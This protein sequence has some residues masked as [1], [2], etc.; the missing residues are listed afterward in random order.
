MRSRIAGRRVTLLPVTFAVA[1]VLPAVALG[2]LGWRL[3]EQDERLERQRVQDR[4]E[5]AAG[6]VTAD[7]EHELAD[8]ERGLGSSAPA[9]PAASVG[10]TVRLDQQGQVTPVAGARLAYDPSP[11]PRP[12]EPP[13]TAWAEAERLEFGARDA[14]GAA[15]A[16]ERLAASPDPQVRAGALVRGARVLRRSGR[17]DDALELYSALARTSGLTV[18]GDP[19]DL[20][21]RWARVELLAAHGRAR[22]ARAEAVGLDLDLR[23]GRW[24]LDRTTALT[25]LGALRPWRG[26]EDEA[27]TTSRVALT[28]GVA[29]VW[30]DWRAGA[31]AHAL[32]SG[33]RSLRV[34]GREVLVVW[35]EVGDDLVVYAAEPASLFEA[36]RR[37]RP[38]PGLAVALLDS[39]GRL[40]AGETPPPGGG[41]A[42]TRPGSDTRLPWTVRVA[43]A[44]TPSE[45]AA[46]GAARR[47]VIVAGLALLAFLVPATGYL[48]ARAVQRELALARQQATFVAAVSHEFR[49]PLT[50]LSHLLSLLRSDFQPS[51]ERRRQY[52]EV[53]ARETDRLRRFV[54]TLLDF[55]RIQAGEARYS[56]RPIDAAPVVGAVVEDFRGHAACGSHPVSLAADAAV[57][58]LSADPEALGRA[59]WNLLENAA[60]YSPDQTSITVRIEEEDGRVA[61]RVSDRGV[62]VP[63][64]EQPFVFDPFFRGAAAADS[65]VKGTGVGLAL[66]RHVAEAHGG[67]VRLESAPGEGSTFSILLPA[68]AGPA[69][70]AARRVS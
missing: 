11:P 51:P 53:M 41:P 9:T 20:M 49:S 69:P 26:D 55:G 66:V 18:I 34:G 58:P 62:G 61:I 60:K 56:P 52:Y 31:S 44:S 57:P 8:V 65:A 36:G 32:G 43:A 35:R 7:L 38:T 47:R 40:L 50:S 24:R 3:I 25:Y 37:S 48:V 46:A 14:R 19:A 42:V 5:S 23:E 6:G 27:R 16:Y 30:S 4:V 29:T 28:G 70:A 64:A 59:L 15:R 17:I 54:E 45:L 21:A 22:E 10:L 33:R 63:V 2:G 1:T 68:A 13:E 67:E 39:Q 12:R